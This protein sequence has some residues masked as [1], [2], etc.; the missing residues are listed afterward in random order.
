MLQRLL[1]GAVL[2]TD[3]H[4]VAR[5]YLHPDDLVSAIV[6]TAVRSTPANGAYVLASSRAQV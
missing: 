3:E 6:V 1:A 2:T 4:N 5:D